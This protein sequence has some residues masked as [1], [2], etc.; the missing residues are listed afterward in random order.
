MKRLLYS[1]VI[2]FLLLAIS[3][4]S[5]DF[6]DGNKKDMFI[7]DD[8]LFINNRQDQ[9]SVTLDLGDIPESDYTILL[10][11]KFLSFSDMHGKTSSSLLIPFSIDKDQIPQ[12]YQK[13]YSSIVLDVENTGLIALTVEFENLGNPLMLCSVN[14][15]TFDNSYSQ[16]FTITNTGPG[17]LKWQ[18]TGIP[19]WLT[20]SFT[21]ASL[22]TSSS[23]TISASLVPEMALT[24]QELKATL[25][26]I[27]NSVN[28]NLDIPVRVSPL[29]GLPSVIKHI[30]GI[31][32]DAEFSHESG[33]L[34][35]ITKSPNSLIIINTLT[36]ASSTMSLSKSPAC[37]SIS[38]DGSKAL[39]GYTENS[40]AYIDV[41]SL[42]ITNEYS[43]D[44]S[45]FDVVLG[46]N[47]WAYITPV[48][49]QWVRFRSFDLNTGQMFTG[50][51][52]SEIYE[53]TILRKIPGKPYL[54][55]TR[56][57]LS[58]SGF[59][60][61]DITNGKANDLFNYYHEALG[62]FWISSDGTR[63][64][65]SPNKIYLI[66]EYD[67]EYHFTSPPLVGIIESQLY[68]ISGLDECPAINS[69]F[70]FSSH[71]DY[72]PQLATVI[73]QYNR[74]SLTRIASFHIVPA[75][76]TENGTSQLYESNPRFIFVNK[77]GTELYS[78]NNIKESLQKNCWTIQV[79]HIGSK[80]L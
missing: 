78:V 53:K 7:L 62:N 61:F 58:P 3:S 16:T 25:K 10:F 1:P 46:D 9:G 73:E 68:Y 49:G 30:D 77:Q 33:I 38:E 8:T 69:V 19:D 45:P 15:I 55:G 37:I 57:F 39:I 14:S 23:M 80:G 47:G 2:L 59:L 40:I 31:V 50:S 18:I 21:T 72:N 32:T 56:T 63:L 34:A 60:I 44:I 5:D 71:Y 52:S 17:L 4:C 24:G 75:E 12:S 41:T 36:D 79:F 66:P 74:E 35:I 48:D 22:V 27:S 13:Y 51:A 28:G 54:V 11:P 43:I 26:I 6:L 29:T 70:F 64:Y 67:G 65:S 42:A 20:L 76:V